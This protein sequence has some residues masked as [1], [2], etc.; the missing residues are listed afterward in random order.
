MI[1][2]NHMTSPYQERRGPA[3]GVTNGAAVSTI[4]RLMRQIV[5]AVAMAVLAEPVPAAFSQPADASTLI[6]L[7][8]EVVDRLVSGQVE[9]LFQMFN[10][11]MK[12][13]ID[14]D[15]LR[16]MI[17]SRIAQLG[18]FKSQVGARTESQD[19]LRVVFITCAFE[20]ANVDVRIAFD[21]FD[22]VVGIGFRPPVST[23]S[24]APPAYV[25]P[26][27]FRDES[28]TVDAG[29]WPLPGTLSLP[30]GEGPFPGV[31][32]V[33]GSGPNDRDESIGPNRP[34]R[35]LAEGLA[36]RGV[37][38]L[39]YDKRTRVHAGRIAGLGDFTV[40]DEVVD[41]AIAAVA[42]MRRSRAIRSD[43]VFVLGHSLG[44]MLAPRIAAG[45][46]AIAGLVVMA[47]PSKS[48]DQAIADQTRYLALLDGQI[49]AE[50]QKMLDA[51]ARLAAD[52]KALKPSDPPIVAPG[53]SAP[54]SYWIDLRG[55]DPPSAA[56]RL[57]QPMLVLQGERDYQ[58]TMEDFGAWKRALGSRPNV[59]L[60]SYPTLNHLFL[61]GAGPSTPAE[62]SVPGHVDASVVADI[63]AWIEWGTV[64]NSP[65]GENGG[66]SPTPYSE[67]S[68][69][70]GPR[71]PI[72]NGAT[73][74]DRP[75]PHVLPGASWPGIRW[76]TAPLSRSTRSADRTGQRRTA[77]T[78]GTG[79]RL[80]RRR[81]R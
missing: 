50:E 67:R 60:K 26:S 48:L 7:A 18:P 8:R 57:R 12:A 79:R 22:R 70:I 46:P 13:A 77:A 62:Y 23:V 11:K 52:V 63:A 64:P 10:E 65:F 59:E 66:L 29:G 53:V 2:S 80:L 14:A 73:P 25:T 40:K 35:D 41:D 3:E 30:V 27:A 45:D 47:G 24:Y 71:L 19:V 33:H 43:R 6:P 42:A 81:C 17:P 74:S 1:R 16:R 31:V 36:S 28:L 44:G 15:G 55:Y 38:V 68:D 34:F 21:T 37:A 20:R 4:T 69:T 49:S 32:L 9:P 54:A 5:L 51:A 75:G 58:V 72:R 56:V 61:A 39:R 78:T 76:R